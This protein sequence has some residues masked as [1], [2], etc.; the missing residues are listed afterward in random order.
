MIVIEEKCTGCKR[1]LRECPLDIISLDECKVTISEDC[2]N[3]RACKKVCPVDALVEEEQPF[4]ES[5][6]CFACPIHCQ[7]RMGKMGVCRR[8]INRDGSRS[9]VVPNLFLI[10][11]CTMTRCSFVLVIPT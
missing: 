9:S 10:N 11:A 7:I 1:C 2:T 6:K 8:F 3:C 4:A 5:I